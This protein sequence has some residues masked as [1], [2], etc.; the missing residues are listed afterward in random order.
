MPVRR[1]ARN[2]VQDDIMRAADR[3]CGVFKAALSNFA[4]NEEAATGLVGVLSGSLGT[5]FKSASASRGFSALSGAASGAG[6]VIDRSYLKNST[7]K[8]IFMGL[9]LKREKISNQLVGYRQ[10]D[11]LDKYSLEWAVRDA[12][13]YADACNVEEALSMV[14]DKV[15]TGGGKEAPDSLP[16]QIVTLID[17]L[18]VEKFAEFI[19]SDIRKDADVT[20]AADLQAVKAATAKGVAQDVV[21]NAKEI[22]KKH[23]I[24]AS[25]DRQIQLLSLLKLISRS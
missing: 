6:A 19:K 7:L 10:N 23:A 25:L 5:L 15:S 4:A 21:T 1:A 18:S 12:I 24:F 3:Q 11:D 13:Q 22:Y 16:G 20:P 17:G 8:I 2:R 9:D 14:A